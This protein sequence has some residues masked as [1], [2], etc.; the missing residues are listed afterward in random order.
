MKYPLLIALALMTLSACSMRHQKPT[1]PPPPEQPTADWVRDDKVIPMNHHAHLSP[2]DYV[3]PASQK[4]Q[5]LTPKIR[6]CYLKELKKNPRLYGQLVVGIDIDTAGQVEKTAIKY[7][8]VP[9]LGIEKCVLDHIQGLSFANHDKEGSVG[10]NYAWV[11]TSGATP[12]E[13]TGTLVRLH[14]LYDPEERNREF[15]NQGTEMAPW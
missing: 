11:F 12:L 8:T 9:S 7:S 5:K 2:Y 13:I 3:L 14:R 10:V 1:A 6:R 4:I 15:E